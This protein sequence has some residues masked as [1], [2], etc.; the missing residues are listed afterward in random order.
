MP[1]RSSHWFA[2]LVLIVA[3]A[4]TLS[5]PAQEN[6]QPQ[7]LNPATP[8]KQKEEKLAFF[9]ERLETLR[10]VTVASPDKPFRFIGEPLITFENPVSLLRLLFAC[11]QLPIILSALRVI[12]CLC[13]GSSL[14]RPS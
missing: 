7:P 6:H 4:A 10:L 5:L 3:G 1:D 14:R 8:D 2:G 13:T 9:R 11:L 12:L